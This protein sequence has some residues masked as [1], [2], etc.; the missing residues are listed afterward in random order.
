MTP[1][2]WDF[3]LK[4]YPIMYPNVCT[5][6]LTGAFLGGLGIIDRLTVYV[7]AGEQKALSNDFSSN[8]FGGKNENQF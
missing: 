6:M 2:L 3:P 4:A 7:R 5:V 8:C 1:N